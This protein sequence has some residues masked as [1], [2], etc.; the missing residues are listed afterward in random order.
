MIAVLIRKLFIFVSIS[1]QIIMNKLIALT[2]IKKNKQILVNISHIIRVDT[3]T[4]DEQ[5][6][7]ILYLTGH[8]GMNLSIEVSES[9]DVIMSIANS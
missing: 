2:P 5:E 1:K 6:T 7:S 8:E 4:R 3:N 9:I